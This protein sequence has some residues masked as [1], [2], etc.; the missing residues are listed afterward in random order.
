M[1]DLRPILIEQRGMRLSSPKGSDRAFV[2]GLLLDEAANPEVLRWWD[3]ADAEDVASKIA[4]DE[5]DFYILIIRVI[6]KPIGLI[7]F[8]IEPDPKY[9]HAAIDIAIADQFQGQ[10]YAPRAIKA[11]VD[12][13]S[14]Q[15]H[16]RFMIDP[17]AANT[18]A[19]KAYK[20]VGFQ[21]IGRIPKSEFRDETGR[22]EDQLLMALVREAA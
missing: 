4:D 7:Q 6:G 9:R 15:G 2:E 5:P 21:E 3:D 18:A 8:S 22:W 10:G 1:A 12:W 16:H 20:K 11:L 13:L 17:N 19:I 14:A